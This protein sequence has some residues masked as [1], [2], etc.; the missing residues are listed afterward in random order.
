MLT[1]FYLL[2]AALPLLIEP[3][4]HAIL[5]GDAGPFSYLEFSNDVKMLAS[6][7][8]RQGKQDLVTAWDIST[9]SRQATF[10]V[11]E[12]DR[13]CLSANGET[14]ATWRFQDP[15]DPHGRIRL[16]DT[17]RRTQRLSIE[18]G[19]PIQRVEFSPRGDVVVSFHPI[20]VWDMTGKERFKVGPHSLGAV[21]PAGDWLATL[22]MS[23]STPERPSGGPSK[24]TLWDLKTGCTR[25]GFQT[26][27]APIT[28]M[29]FS[30]TGRFLLTTG[31]RGM[32]LWE[33]AT[34]KQVAHFDIDSAN[35]SALAFAPD[36][37]T[38]AVV[39][40]RQLMLMDVATGSERRHALSADWATLTFSRQNKVLLV[41]WP[42]VDHVGVGA[43]R[44]IEQVG[45][46]T[47]FEPDTMTELVTL[48]QHPD[49]RLVVSQ[50]GSTIARGEPDGSIKLWFTA[51]LLERSSQK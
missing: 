21:S 8:R 50:D 5:R 36:S 48:I 11:D 34:A 18:H 6:C 4:P 39:L 16:W 20:R 43:N 7:A 44:Q 28:D 38:L 32:D 3:P 19:N 23:Q 26:S 17:T 14:L 41:R 29:E 25:M 10:M 2:L 37:R 35:V 31:P 13:V 49:T 46:I 12:G 42:T 51:K 47:C 22:E 1:G 30:P 27:N 24:V 45:R 15:S 33:L 40:R 9:K